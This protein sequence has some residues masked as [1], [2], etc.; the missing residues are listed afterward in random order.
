MLRR[1]PAALALTLLAPSRAGPA[2]VREPKAIEV[3]ELLYRTCMQWHYNKW[4][5]AGDPNAE[6]ISNEV[7]CWRKLH[8]SG[9]KTFRTAVWQDLETGQCAFQLSGYGGMNS[10]NRREFTEALVWPPVSIKL[11]G[12]RLYVPFVHKLRVHINTSDFGKQMELLAG[13]KSTCKGEVLVSG[14]SLGGALAEMVAGCGSKGKLHEL[15]DTNKFYTNW[16]VGE[17]YT[18]APQ[19]SSMEPIKNSQGEGKGK[20]F[21]GKRF[22]FK[23]DALG[24]VTGY[25]R[26]RHPR[27]ET[28]EFFRGEDGPTYRVYPCE[29]EASTADINHRMPPEL[30]LNVTSRRHDLINMR[31]G[32]LPHDM[33]FHKEALRWFYEAEVLNFTSLDF[34]VSKHGGQLVA[35]DALTDHLSGNATGDGSKAEPEEDREDS[36]QL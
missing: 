9:D 6:R 14:V 29:S 33:N 22:Y 10:T 7:G 3:P 31:K 13:P 11:C 23:G 27:I 30:T 8:V 12:Y 15:F 25:L 36:R 24:F 18:F 19:A 5:K 21:K 4:A 26:Y 34:P 35:S 16:T 20:C 28:V 1:L 17:V 32:K 2:C